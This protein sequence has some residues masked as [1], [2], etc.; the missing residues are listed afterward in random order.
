MAN[1]EPLRTISDCFNVSILSVFRII[2]RLIAWLLTKTDEI[3]TWP[4]HEKVLAVCKGF[5]SKRIPQLLRAIDCTHI[6][7]E[8]PSTSEQ[9]YCNR[10]KFFSIHLQAI[11]DSNMRFTNVYIG[12][13]GSLHDARIL[14][15]SLIYERANEE[16][17]TVFPNDT[18]LLGDSAYPSLPWL[19]PPFH[20]NGH[21]TPQQIEFN[22]IHSSTPVMRSF[23]Q[24]S[25]LRC[26]TQPYR[27]ATSRIRVSSAVQSMEESE[28]L[29]STETQQTINACYLHVKS[30]RF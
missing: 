30:K 3:I 5:F 22:F 26:L 11:V 17:E 21:L 12:E 19:V 8:K 4:Q 28:R 25:R 15:M 23:P 16:K 18:F 20:D 2:R 29:P 7:I 9:L 1:T 13:P 14:K 27:S 10:K 6:R 24:R